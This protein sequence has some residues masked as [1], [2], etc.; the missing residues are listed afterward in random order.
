[1]T[2]RELIP[3]RISSLPARIRK[4]IN[5]R[6]HA[7]EGRSFQALAYLDVLPLQPNAL[8]PSSPL[9]SICHPRQQFQRQPQRIRLSQADYLHCLTKRRVATPWRGGE[10][11]RDRQLRHFLP[12][13]SPSLTRHTARAFDFSCTIVCLFG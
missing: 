7:A 6:R 13:C 9:H 10:C 1:M 4:W 3:D 5:Q 8:C 11:P 12:D 2:Q